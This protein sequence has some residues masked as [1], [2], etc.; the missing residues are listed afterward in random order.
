[1]FAQT[2]FCVT[3][4]FA[5]TRNKKIAG[6]R[7]DKHYAS[8]VSHDRQRQRSQLFEQHLFHWYITCAS[9]ATLPPGAPLAC[10]AKMARLAVLLF[11]IRRN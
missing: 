5:V 4:V 10:G 7:N 3:F 9:I 11:W 2:I 6:T 1:M 8:K